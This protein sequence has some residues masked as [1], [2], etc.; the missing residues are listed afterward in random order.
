MSVYELWTFKFEVISE[1]NYTFEQREKT[2][3]NIICDN[4]SIY[5]HLVQNV[6]KKKTMQTF[7]YKQIVFE[8]I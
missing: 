8:K 6:I 7:S 4:A 2:Y 1:K 5:Q 3:F